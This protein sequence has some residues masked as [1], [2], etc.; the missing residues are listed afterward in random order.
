MPWRGNIC[1]PGVPDQGCTQCAPL[2]EAPTAR[3]LPPR[4]HACHCEYWTTG[5]LARHLRD[6]PDCVGRLRQ[7]GYQ[8]STIVP[9]S[10]AKSDVSKTTR[11][12]AYVALCCRSRHNGTGLVAR[13][14]EPTHT[15]RA[16]A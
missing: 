13:L 1:G 3:Y 2:Q 4:C 7:A 11:G 14:S 10:A 8:T 16:V 5:R 12:L 9:G 6:S 15:V